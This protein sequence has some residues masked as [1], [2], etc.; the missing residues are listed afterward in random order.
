MNFQYKL[1][2]RVI[3]EG[4]F[5]TQPVTTIFQWTTFTFTVLFS[6]AFRVASDCY[7]SYQ[8]PDT[9]FFCSK[10]TPENEFLFCPTKCVPQNLALQA[11][12][13]KK[14]TEI[15]CRPIRIQIRIDRLR[16][17]QL[18]Q[19]LHSMQTT[20]RHPLTCTHTNHT[21]DQANRASC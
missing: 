1:K 14:K 7:I 17:L 10:K 8:L 2:T 11:S 3:K 16:I 9:L 4:Q 15:Q 20:R 5:C 6:L 13:G 12:K 21:T 19:Y 18:M